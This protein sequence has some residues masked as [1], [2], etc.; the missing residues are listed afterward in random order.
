MFGLN[1]FNFSKKTQE[2]KPVLKQE[3]VTKENNEKD[4]LISK[5]Q[6][7]NDEMA[8]EIKL[9]TKKYDNIN[10]KHETSLQMGLK[11]EKKINKLIDEYN[12]LLL[13]NEKL[14]N[15][16]NY[17]IEITTSMESFIN[18]YVFIVKDG[19]ITIATLLE[20]FLK[21]PYSP[22][23]IT[24]FNSKANKFLKNDL[25]DYIKLKEELRTKIEDLRKESEKTDD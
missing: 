2:E 16:Y 4:L 10:I 22:T 6:K 25:S 20:S 7:E 5:L 23:A 13:E 17:L 15:D 24:N 18:Q 3:E 11:H 19:V 21:N 8:S 9:L 12:G 1:F 14:T